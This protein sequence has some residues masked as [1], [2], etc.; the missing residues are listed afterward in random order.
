MLT[1]TEE[2]AVPHTLAENGS[3]VI[4]LHPSDDVVISLDQLV[5]GARLDRKSVV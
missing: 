3:R 4:R 2:K 1:K 5:S